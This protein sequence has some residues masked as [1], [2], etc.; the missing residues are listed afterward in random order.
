MEEAKAE[1]RRLV[2]AEFPDG[3]TEVE[4]YPSD[5]SS[6][7][8]IST[9]PGSFYLSIGFSDVGIGKIA[10]RQWNPQQGFHYVLED[11]PA[12]GMAVEDTTWDQERREK[13][14]EK[15][16]EGETGVDNV[17]LELKSDVKNEKQPTNYRV[18]IQF[19]SSPKNQVSLQVDSGS[20]IL[21]AQSRIQVSQ[22]VPPG[23]S[24]V[25]LTIEDAARFQEG[26]KAYEIVYGGGKKV[27][28]SLFETTVSI[29]G[30]KTPQV[31]GA[32][33]IATQ[34]NLL[35]LGILG[36]G[37]SADNSP[38]PFHRTLVVHLV[39]SGMIK[40]A[41]F[42]LIGPRS[43]P[44]GSIT[45][46]DDKTRS[47]GWLVVGNLPDSYHNGITWCPAL[48]EK[49]RAWVVRLN[50]VTVNGVV[51]CEDQLALVDTGSSYL[52][53]TED[54]CCDIAKLIQGK[55]GKGAL[56]YPS[57]G[58]SDFS[59]TFGDA[60]GEATFG[61]NNEDLSLGPVSGSGDGF[62]RSPV[63]Y[64]SFGNRKYDWVLGGIFIDN[65]ISIFDYTGAPRVGFA[66][67]SG[68]DPV[69]T[70]I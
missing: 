67:R 48:A 62:L 66:S 2:D 61:L 28:F 30:L 46:S 37:F 29:G 68:V 16:K 5:Y 9:A 40:R 15:I 35:P 3:V 23:R 32:A 31:F 11:P 41:S 22:D 56:T 69:I 19:G 70:S 7:E 4:F 18:N 12:P 13:E 45:P 10:K 27:A 21:W 20:S 8:D 58:L 34:E 6:D 24:V 49:Y 51:V 57:G 38:I 26:S 1:V 39:E 53:T 52:I 54:N 42:A 33:K 64:M 17:V 47:R 60:A 25:D 59:F 55:V 50:K 36:L 44:A 14:N 63:T 43:E 65:M